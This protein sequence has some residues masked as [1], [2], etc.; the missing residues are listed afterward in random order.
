MLSAYQRHVCEM[1]PLHID[2]PLIISHTWLAESVHEN[3]EQSSPRST[4]YKMDQ[5]LEHYISLVVYKYYIRDMIIVR[6]FP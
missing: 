5:Y 1:L 3:D 2:S 4:G 6:M